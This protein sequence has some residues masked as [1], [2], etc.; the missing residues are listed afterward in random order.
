MDEK[1]FVRFL[2]GNFRFSPG[3]GIGDDASVVK[4][5]DSHQL[6]TKDILIE[7]VH[8]KLDYFSIEEITQKALAVN[9]S[10]IAAMGGETDYFY[11]GLKF[12]P[13]LGEKEIFDFFRGLKKGCR[14]W[15]VELAGGDFSSS[16]AMFISITMV[17][18]AENPVFREGARENDLVGITGVTGESAMG[19]QLLEKSIKT[20]PFVT[21]HKIVKPELNKGRLLSRF[22]N[23]MIDVSDGLVIDLSRILTASRKGANLFYEKIPVTQKMSQVCAKYGLDEYKTVLAGGEDFVLLFTISPEKEPALRECAKSGDY[24][25]I[26]EVTDQDNEVVITHNGKEISPKRPGY[27]HLKTN[28]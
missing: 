15:Q 10:D 22:V 19:L 3:K 5:G 12:P 16:P 14:Q 2:E 23:T 8:F 4:M 6:I 13:R 7:N 26:G 1:G 27:D 17:G 25:I 24:Y 20:G 21:K 28:L 11:L 9:L 18:R